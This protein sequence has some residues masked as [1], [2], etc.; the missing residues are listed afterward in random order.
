MTFFEFTGHLHYCSLWQFVAEVNKILIE[1]VARLN[2]ALCSHFEFMYAKNMSYI[3]G[4]TLK[5][6]E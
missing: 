3:H 5:V 6:V 2:T 4:H 1:T